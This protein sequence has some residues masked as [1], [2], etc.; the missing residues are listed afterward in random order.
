MRREHELAR[1]IANRTNEL[2][3][4][5]DRAIPGLA[6]L[7]PDPAQPQA[8]AICRY[9]SHPGRLARQAPENLARTL[10]SQ[11]G[12][13]VSVEEAATLVE[14]ARQAVGPGAR[15]NPPPRPFAERLAANFNCSTS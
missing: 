7:L 6:L 2:R 13:P 5:L 9:W 1:R 11:S 8:Q 3:A 14:L 4:L 15:R 10:T 12:R